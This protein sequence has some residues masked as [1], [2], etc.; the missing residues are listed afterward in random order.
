MRAERITPTALSAAACNSKA[1]RTALPAPSGRCQPLLNTMNRASSVPYAR[2][3][4]ALLSG[5]KESFA[6][7]NLTKH[8]QPSFPMNKRKPLTIVSI[9]WDYF[10][11][12]ETDTCDW[13]H[14]ENTGFYYEL[15]W[16]I[17]ATDKMFPHGAKTVKTA[18][19][20]LKVSPK[21]ID[22]VLHRTIAPSQYTPL[23]VCDSHKDIVTFCK[24]LYEGTKFNIV[25]LD[26]HHDYSYGQLVKLDCGNWAGMLR[27]QKRLAN[28][29]LVYP[30][31]RKEFPESDDAK[32]LSDIN[33]VIYGDWPDKPI[34]ADAVF[35][36][37]SSCWMP[38]WLDNEWLHM[39]ETAK[40]ICNDNNPIN[41]PYVM[42]ARPFEALQF[43]GLAG[44]TGGV[45]ITVNC[46]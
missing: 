20:E 22:R 45:Q 25:N 8:V 7:V 42:K 46:Q 23:C 44:M 35:I 13:G 36:C 10:L 43:P 32:H 24:A 4:C 39:I 6:T 30:K 18:I 5:C 15:A 29:T 12:R 3:I 28:Y 33:R 1:R 14:S 34:E 27:K 41:A 9:D 16:G 26:A 11:P 31:W 19:E 2:L 38:S 17:R 21:E 37:R 40:L